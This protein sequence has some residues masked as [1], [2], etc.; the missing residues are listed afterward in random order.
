MRYPLLCCLLVA[1]SGCDVSDS[2]CQGW[3]ADW[4]A[5][6]EEILVLVNDVRASGY[7]CPE[8][9]FAAAGPVVDEP[10]LRCA[11]RLHSMDMAQ[12]DFFDHVGSDG[13]DLVQRVEE[14]GYLEW[15]AVGENIAAGYPSPSDTL[16]Q[17]LDSSQGHCGNLMEPGFQDLGVGLYV[18][19]DSEYGWY[20]TQNFGVLF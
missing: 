15:S 7:A 1:L 3:D 9:D 5:L 11:A 13:S 17:W 8:G 4:A 19:P 10:A 12:N 2:P 18:E 20:W 6:E 14:Q 16:Q